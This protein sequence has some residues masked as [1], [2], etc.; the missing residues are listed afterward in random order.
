MKTLN[1]F[2]NV[3]ISPFLCYVLLLVLG[4]LLGQQED[5]YFL[6]IHLLLHSCKSYLKKIRLL[7]SS[8]IFSLAPNP[9]IPS[10]PSLTRPFVPFQ[11]SRSSGL[12]FLP[13]VWNQTVSS[14]ML[15]GCCPEQHLQEK[16][17]PSFSPH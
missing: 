2:L 1:Y 17:W 5:I 3:H 10:S 12:A 7:V 13:S 16:K 14:S 11:S 8:P 15:S 4:H 9:D 6:W